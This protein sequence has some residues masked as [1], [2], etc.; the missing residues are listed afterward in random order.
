MAGPTFGESSGSFGAP[1]ASGGAGGFVLPFLTYGFGIANEG[2]SFFTTFKSNPFQTFEDFFEGK[3]AKADTIAAVLRAG[4]SRNP[5]ID[6]LGRELAILE[7]GGVLLS[8]SSAAGQAAISKVLAA[9]KAGLVAQGTSPQQASREILNLISSHTATPG[10][11]IGRPQVGTVAFP[12]RASN[13]QDFANQ[14]TPIP[15]LPNPLAPQGGI[16]A[17]PPNV[18]NILRPLIPGA[19]ELKAL[20]GLDIFGQPSTSIAIPPTRP[21]PQPG[22]PQSPMTVIDPR[23][24]QSCNPEQHAEY[25]RL[26]AQQGDLQGELQTEENQGQAQQDQQR[27]QEIQKFRQLEQQPADQRNIPQEIQRKMALLEQ[28]GQELGQLQNQLDNPTTGQVVQPGSG[29]TPVGSSTPTS[30]PGNQSIITPDTSPQPGS[31]ETTEHEHEDEEQQ[32][33]IQQTPKENQ[34]DPSQA[35]K[36]CV[37]CVTQLEAIK[38]LNGEP[39]GCSV[40]GFPT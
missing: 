31:A 10:T 11:A 12:E 4:A 26:K 3:P 18:A 7:G 5:V 1:G 37:G 36:F 15:F 30:Q 9:A 35:V 27:Q 39:S 17:L 16:P 28:I 32:V 8:D 19:D 21:A 14:F 22:Q 33:F 6:K 25:Q 38:F 29:Q 2:L 20:T 40:M 13:A 23:E 24:C 34:G